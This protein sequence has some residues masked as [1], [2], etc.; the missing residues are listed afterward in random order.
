[1]ESIL[2]NYRA[3][4]LLQ[5]KYSFA[6]IYFSMKIL[7]LSYKFSWRSVR[8][9]RWQSPNSKLMQRYYEQLQVAEIAE[10]LSKVGNWMVCA[11]F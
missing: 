7:M 9:L 6:G 5:H 2:V 10:A 3:S 11:H 1:M 8:S 4:R